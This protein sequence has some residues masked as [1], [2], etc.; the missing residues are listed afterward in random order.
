MQAL[1]IVIPPLLAV[2]PIAA[3]GVITTSGSMPASCSVGSVNVSLVRQSNKQLRG[4]D[5]LPISQTGET[6]WTLS[7]TQITKGT[8]V[9]PMIEVRGFANLDL[10]STQYSSEAVTVKGKHAGKADVTA[11]LDGP[12]GIDPGDYA[13]L[14]TL[15]CEVQ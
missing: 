4:T 12:G 15:I 10:K 8:G 14:T 1:P 11:T 6:K 3:P 7:K 9:T 5:F 13:T 2:A